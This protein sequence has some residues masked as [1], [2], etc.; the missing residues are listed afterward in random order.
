MRLKETINRIFGKAPEQQ[1]IPEQQELLD[2]IDDLSKRL[3][4]AHNGI[5]S[6]AIYK[7]GTFDVNS[8]R[9]QVYIQTL[10]AI[11]EKVQRQ[12]EHFYPSEKPQDVRMN[13]DAEC[14]MPLDLSK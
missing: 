1:K 5:F 10:T 6:R 2:H 9:G 13:V 11:L 7:E 3:E 4:K 14:G 12:Y 8:E